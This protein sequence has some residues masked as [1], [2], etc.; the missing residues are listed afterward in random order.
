MEIGYGRLPSHNY[1][2]ISYRKSFLHNVRPCLEHETPQ[3][4]TT[5][6]VRTNTV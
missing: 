4:V 5:P 3:F 2:R 1:N 6:P